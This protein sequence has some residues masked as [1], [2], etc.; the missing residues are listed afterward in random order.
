MAVAISK[1]IEIDGLGGASFGYWKLVNLRAEL[2]PNTVLVTMMP[3]LDAAAAAASKTAPA[4]AR[5]YTLTFAQAGV[6]ANAN[7]LGSVIVGNY[8]RDTILT[9]ILNNV[10]EFIGGSLV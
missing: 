5:K 1:S 9:H 2:G 7:T 6:S 3:S 8:L 10:S 4:H